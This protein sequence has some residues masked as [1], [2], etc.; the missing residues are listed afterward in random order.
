MKRRFI[1][2]FVVSFVL[3]FGAGF[4]VLDFAESSQMTSEEY[5]AWISET[6]DFRFGKDKPFSPSNANTFNGQFIKGEDFVAS[7]RCGECHTDMHP[8]W[9]QSAHRNSFREPFYQKN[10]SDLIRQKNIAFTRHCESCHNPAALFA[11]ALTDKPQFKDRPYDNEGVSCI[12]CHSIQSVSGKGIGG[13]VMGQPALLEKADGTKVVQATNQQIL[14][15]IGDHKRAMM[16]DVLKK[17]EFCGA[18]HKSQVPH[19]LN[20]YKFLRAFAVADELQQSSFSK[21]SPHPFYVRDKETC[22]SCHMKDVNAKN[23]DV[24]A[25]DGMISSHR[26]ATANTAIPTFFG[27]TEQVDEVKKFLQDDKMGVDIFALSVKQEGKSKEKLIAPVNRKDFKIKAGD[28]LTAD[29]VVTNKNIGHSFPPELRDFYEAYVEF[30]VVDAS[31]K[32]IFK[33]GYM[34][35]DG[36]LDETTH[37]YKTHLVKEDGSYNDLHYIWKTKVVAYNLAI[38]SGRSDL[39]RYKFTVPQDINSGQIKLVA[40]LQYRRFTRVF[41]DY[42]L[43]KSTDLPVV[44][45]ARSER[46]ILIGEE[47]KAQTVDPKAVPDWRRWNNYGIALL[48]Q[49]Q[50]PQAADAFD[51]VIDSNFKDYKPFAFTNKALALMEMGG[52]KEAEKLVEKS[53]E[54]DQNNLRAVFQLGRIDRV[55]SRLE[56]AEA[57]FKK[58]LEKYPRDRMTLQQL[59]ELAK[60]KSD[61]VA[62]E[63]RKDQLQVAKGFYDQ[64]L[65]LD[66]ED[67][68]AHYNLMI[69]YQKLGMREEAKKE[70]K[71]FQDLKDDPAVTALASNFLQTNW[72]IGNESLPF[73]THDLKPFSDAMQKMDYVGWVSLK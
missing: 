71:I 41:S 46:N 61:T 55:R 53:I 8:Q 68:G 52:W 14:N 29:V 2:L 5:T 69:I 50:F 34:K 73:H 3:L 62:P 19:E 43:A 49:R 67:V 25:K 11:G 24:S 9:N 7:A 31:G 66:P 56:S 72:N 10:V 18:C 51:E 70:A 48:D 63:Q 1:K 12:A 38:P 35:P 30:C 57:N 39:A 40:K 4:F 33:S 32:E 47:T 22:N 64:I 54:L 13:Y 17:P 15:N 42:V 65:E 23:F 26:W 16:R 21:E 6:Y 45:M 28:T 20:D 60:I 37:A 36:H 58:V 27:Y 44:E 59:G